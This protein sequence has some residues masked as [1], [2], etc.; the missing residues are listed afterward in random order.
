MAGRQAGRQTDRQADRQTDRQ[1]GRQAD[2]D[3]QTLYR[4]RHTDT[5]THT[6]LVPRISFVRHIDETPRLCG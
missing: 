3:G 2:R 6:D 1:A 4:H 5:S